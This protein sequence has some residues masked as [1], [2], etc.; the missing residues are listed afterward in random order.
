MERRPNSILLAVD[1]SDQALEAVRYVGNLLPPKQA[2]ITLFH[3]LDRI[4]HS[5]WD[6]EANPGLRHKVIGVHAWEFQQK[7][8]IQGFMERA[9]QL[10]RGAGHPKDSILTL[11]QERQVGIAR[12]II[13]EAKKGYDAVVM[14][15]RGM[16]PVKDL[17]FGSTANKLVSRLLDVPVWVVGGS[18]STEKLLVAV[19]RSEGAQRA[20]N[21]VERFLAGDGTCCECLLFHVL[22]GSRTFVPDD[23][24][25]TVPKGEEDW[26][27]K[28]EQEFEKAEEEMKAFFN[29]TIQQWSRNGIDTSRVS[30]KIS[31]GESRA[32]NIVDQAARAGYGTIV[33]GRR[34]MSKVEE[35]FMGRVSNKVLQLAKEMAVWV[36]H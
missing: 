23:E 13:I 9:N 32:G 29:E 26:Q 7:K 33:V 19:D 6:L 35:F 3:V 14:G 15:R 12:D 8:L 36:V 10:L 31:R 17:L 2:K 11:L 34:G 20:L 1:G 16:S 24:G 22:R 4:P 28:V 5:Y 30:S 18:P 21:Y 27:E 25:L